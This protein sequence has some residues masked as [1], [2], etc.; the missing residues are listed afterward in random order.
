MFGLEK[1]TRMIAPLKALALEQRILLGVLVRHA[2]QT[3]A[4]VEAIEAMNAAMDK[5]DVLLRQLGVIK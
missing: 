5:L 1:Y 4:D 3:G 2:K